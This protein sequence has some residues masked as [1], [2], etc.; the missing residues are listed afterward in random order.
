[1]YEYIFVDQTYTDNLS[2]HQP[3]NGQYGL[4][5]QKD[6]RQVSVG[7]FSPLIALGEIPCTKCLKHNLFIVDVLDHNNPL[8]RTLGIR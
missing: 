4:P 5:E 3:L 6:C 8:L 2:C 7:H 1:M